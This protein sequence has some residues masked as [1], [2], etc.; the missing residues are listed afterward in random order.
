LHSA[1]DL[2]QLTDRCVKCGMCLQ[3]CP[4][5]ALTR[6]EAESPRGRIA[7]IQ[8]LV[9]GQLAYSEKL[10][11]HL[12]NCLKCRAC[13]RIC[14]SMVPYGELIDL[15]QTYIEQAHRHRPFARR[16]LLSLA[17]NAARLRLAARLLRLYQRSGLQWLARTSGVLGLLGLTRVEAQLP[18]LAGT[19]RWRDY[20]PAT[21]ARRADVALFTGCIAD[22]FDSAT[23]RAAITVL[24][25]LGYGV[26]VPAAQRCCGALHLHNGEPD[27]ARQLAESNL[28][29]FDPDTVE[30]ILTTATGCAA[31]LL[32]Y[33][34]RVA[35]ADD[36]TRKVT[37]ISTFLARVA[38]PETVRLK[39][40]PRRVAVHDPCSLTHVLRQS[41][42][43]HAVLRRIPDIELVTLPDAARCCGAAGSY[44]LTHPDTADRLRDAKLN[45]LA[46]SGVE[47]LVTS[48]IGCALHLAAGLRQQG[49]AVEVVH[50][51]TLLAR[52]M[53]TSSACS[54]TAWMS[55]R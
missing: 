28:A 33:N 41:D 27:G 8:G 34:Q 9:N 12:G 17:T 46:T 32:E 13:E 20:Y 24:T 35:G 7:L 6:D 25:S 22:A 50:P 21:G 43:P 26:R 2:K 42:R 44:M 48:N 23:T 1:S 15:A 3:Q 55:P 40:L 5:Y 52:Q 49:T 29:A 37:D 19:E 51:V 53:E 18:R 45:G 11:T 31:T 38:W 10:D 39:P 54:S 36:F 4:T 47:T 14:P 30:A 16:L